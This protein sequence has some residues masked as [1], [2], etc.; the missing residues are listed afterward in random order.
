MGRPAVFLDRDGTMVQEVDYLREIS[1]LRLLRGTAAAIRRLNEAGFAV[2]LATNQSG[3]ARGLLTESELQT[4]HDE[5]KRRL[6]LQGARLD[7]I[8]HCPHHP[9]AAVAAY[10]KRCRCRKPAPGLLLQAARDLDLDLRRSYAVGDSARDVEAGARA[11]CRTILVRTG[12]GARTEAGWQFGTANALPQP[13]QEMLREMARVARL[14]D[15]GLAMLDAE[16]VVDNLPAAVDWILSRK[17][18]RARSR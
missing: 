14:A 5:L 4:I 9:E 6:A 17:K 7:A 8:Y 3:I 13:K 18:R 15:Q 12:Y 10:R 2:V 11:G 1:Q 16:V